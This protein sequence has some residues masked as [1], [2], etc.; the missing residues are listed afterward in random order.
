M[1]L[2]DRLIILYSCI[3]NK[4]RVSIVH[5]CSHQ[6]SAHLD[7]SRK[8]ASLSCCAIC[9]QNAFPF[10]CVMSFSQ[11]TIARPSTYLVMGPVVDFGRQRSRIPPT[12]M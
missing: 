9:P 3:G 7:T 4:S 2:I 8:T 12:L 5:S 6:I 10:S 11:V 1:R